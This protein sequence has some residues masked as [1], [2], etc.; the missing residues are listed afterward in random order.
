MPR[1]SRRQKRNKLLQGD[2]FFR[3][4]CNA[5]PVSSVCPFMR[6]K[7]LVML[8]ACGG[9]A[10]GC[11]K[12]SAAS[13]ARPAAS[14]LGVADRPGFNGPCAV[15]RPADPMAALHGLFDAGLRF[16]GRSDKAHFRRVLAEAGIDERSQV[17]VFSKT[18]HQNDA[19]T[20]ATPRAVYFSDDCYMGMVQGGMLEF[21]Q[22]DAG[23]GTVFHAI[24]FRSK[25]GDAPQWESPPRCMD[26]HEGPM[27]G[28]RP[29][30]MVRSVFT[31]EGGQPITSAGTFLVSH[32]T[33]ITDRWGGWFVTG[34]HGSARHMGNNVAVRQPDNNATLDRETGAS[35]KTVAGTINASPYLRETS[36]IVALMVLEH[37]V[38]LHNAYTQ[39]SLLVKEQAARHRA[40]M[41]ELGKPGADLSPEIRSL[42]RNQARKIVSQMLFKGEAALPEGGIEGDPGFQEAFRANERKAAGRSLKDFQLLTRL[43]KYRCSYTAYSRAFAQM[44]PM[45]KDA[46]WQ[47]LRGALL[48]ENDLAAHLPAGER[49]QIAEILRETC[50]G[51]GI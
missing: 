1:P 45:L 24:D 48:G 38:N 10:M 12:P 30:L 33:P 47:A 32:E 51:S 3:A 36:D 46:V 5:G 25:R 17:L 18:S 2:A 16:D 37:Q 39:G 49:A 35:Q 23:Q 28:E 15:K 19:I 9:V 21:A 31:D 26:C 40:V 43:F 22:A 20:R 8:V 13:S 4:G 34:E 7:T 41:A 6:Q 50:P 42:I 27:T 29:G 44:D 11:D 14:A